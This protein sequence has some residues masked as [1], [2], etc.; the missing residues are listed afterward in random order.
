M[1]GKRRTGSG[2]LGRELMWV[3]CAALLVGLTLTVG[4][5]QVGADSSSLP[6][7]QSRPAAASGCRQALNN[8]DFEGTGGWVEY[9]SLRASLISSFPPPSGAYHSGQF[10]A[11]LAD[12]NNAHDHIAQEVTLPA[13][14]T[15]V[16]LR[17]WWQ[18]ETAES[19]LRPYDFLTV[20]VDAV[21]G[22]PLATL[23]VLSNQDVGPAWQQSVHDLLAYRGQTVSLR[24]EARTDANRTTAFFLDDVQLRVCTPGA[25][26]HRVY[27]SLV[28]R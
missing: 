28:Q 24:F 6:V 22:T 15:E 2:R 21:S 27:V 3:R 11:Y 16:T 17:Y 10:G 12:Y 7:Q 20:T 9:S 23:E 25:V 26:T 8:D 13:N 19:T 14:A 18:V 4:R 1:S 5:L